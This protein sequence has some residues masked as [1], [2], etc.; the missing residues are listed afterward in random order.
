MEELKKIFLLEKEE[1]EFLEKKNLILSPKF[2]D[3]NLIPK[4]YEIFIQVLGERDCP[5]RIDSS[6]TK[7]KFI[8]VI[9]ALFSPKKLIGGKIARDVR[10][11][12]AELM[13]CSKYAVSHQCENLSFEYLHYHGFS[14]SVD[15][16]INKVL[17]M[18]KN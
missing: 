17:E 2:T 4:I 14:D 8:F 10:D 12:L 16:V 11:K 5:P 9:L 3:V 6:R 15:D 7:K 13:K 18:L 1:K